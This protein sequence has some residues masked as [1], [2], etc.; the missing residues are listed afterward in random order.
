MFSMW[1]VCVCVFLPLMHDLWVCEMPPDLTSWTES[2]SSILVFT[3]FTPN[4][5]C[6]FVSDLDL[7]QTAGFI[8]S[9]RGMFSSDWLIGCLPFW[10]LAPC[11]HYNMFNISY[12]PKQITTDYWLASQFHHQLD[13]AF[14][15]IT[16]RKWLKFLQKKLDLNAKHPGNIKS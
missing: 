10:P 3:C 12:K 11:L 5:A 4:F 8:S 2:T 9:S 1:S 6:T 15:E 13:K 14:R 7:P 16:L